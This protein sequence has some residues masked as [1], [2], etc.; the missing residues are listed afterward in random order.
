MAA[1]GGGGARSSTELFLV[2]ILRPRGE[3]FD[4]DEE[5]LEFGDELRESMLKR[6]RERDPARA[7]SLQTPLLKLSREAEEGPARLM[8]V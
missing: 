2:T 1:G 5:A 4:F 6:A 8:R 7:V 3:K